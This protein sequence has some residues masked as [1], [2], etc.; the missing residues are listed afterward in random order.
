MQQSS[1][2]CRSELVHCWEW[3]HLHHEVQATHQ[4]SLS[5]RSSNLSCCKGLLLCSC[6]A[7]F[8]QIAA[9]GTA[10]TAVHIQVWPMRTPT[11]MTYLSSRSCKPFGISPTEP[12]VAGCICA[13]VQLDALHHG[14]VSTHHTA[15]ACDA[16]PEPRCW[17]CCCCC[18]W[19]CAA[20]PGLRLLPAGLSSSP[21][22]WLSHP[23]RS[24][25]ATPLQQQQTQQQ[26]EQQQEQ[27]AQVQAQQSAAC[28]SLVVRAASS[29]LA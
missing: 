28:T 13:Q 24:H 7:C 17:T 15:T 1:A 27:Q 4:V 2:L 29:V 26:L 20:V 18:R 14:A 6:G 21:A 8:R 12:S 9:G 3:V 5:A 10:G 22:C 11:R 19:I 23:Q 16:V 25:W